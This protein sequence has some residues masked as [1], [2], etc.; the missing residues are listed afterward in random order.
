[1]R[2][3]EDGRYGE[4]EPLLRRVV[5][6]REDKLGPEHPETASA[7]GGLGMALQRGGDLDGAE[8]EYRRALRIYEKAFGPAH[9]GTLLFRG[10]LEDL[11]RQRPDG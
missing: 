10:L 8:N 4:A 7:L 5:Q 6:I 3:V 2:L 9:R 1:M 11:R